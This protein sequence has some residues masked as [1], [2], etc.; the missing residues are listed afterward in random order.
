MIYFRSFIDEWTHIAG[1]YNATTKQA[2]VYINGVIKNATIGCGCLSRDW[3]RE[4][5]IGNEEM[6]RPLSGLI[7]EFRI[8]N[9]ALT[10]DEIKA[11]YEKCKFGQGG[12]S[13]C[14][15]V[16]LISYSQDGS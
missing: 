10:A 6:K 11:L 7:D 13:C 12:K 15:S 1:T 4:A 9:Y 16:D 2:K 3:A 8:Y 14:R 5:K